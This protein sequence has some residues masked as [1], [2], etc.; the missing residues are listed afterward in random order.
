MNPRD[1][2]DDYLIEMKEGKNQDYSHFDFTDLTRI[3]FDLFVAGNDTTANMTRWFLIYMARFQEIQ[4]KI[5]EEIDRVVPRDTLPGLEHRNEL[6]YLDATMNE[7]Q[8][9]C[10]MLPMGL[11]R[12]A[13]KDTKLEGFDIQKGTVVMSLAAL[14]HKDRTYFKDPDKFDPSRFLDENRKYFPT[15]EWISGLWNREKT[16]PRGAIRQ[17]GT[18]SHN[19]CS[20]T[21]LHLRTS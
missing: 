20:A 10:S 12:C 1:L 17:N 9:H 15:C 18:L 8:R 13:A 6:R 4:E 5:Q 3:T 16:M 19:C 14:S 7:V 11:M 21:E 2:M